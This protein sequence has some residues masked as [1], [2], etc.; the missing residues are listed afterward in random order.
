MSL[1]KRR[2]GDLHSR[3][4][5]EDDEHYKRTQEIKDTYH[6]GTI[7]IQTLTKVFEPRNKM[8]RDMGMGLGEDMAGLGE[9]M[10]EM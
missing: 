2:I 1:V 3:S 9:D 8:S 6:A 10:A 4:V 5:D 7:D